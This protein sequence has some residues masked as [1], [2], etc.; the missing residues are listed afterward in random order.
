MMCKTLNTLPN[1]TVLF[2]QTRTAN[3]IPDTVH[4]PYQGVLYSQNAIHFYGT[5]VS[6][7]HLCWHVWLFL[8]RLSRNLH[9]ST[10][11]CT[12]ILNCTKFYSTWAKHDSEYVFQ[13]AISHKMQY[14][15]HKLLWTSP[16]PCCANQTRNSENKGTF[17]NTPPVRYGVYCSDFLRTLNWSLALRGRSATMSFTK[18]SQE[19][20]KL[21]GKKLKIHFD[22]L[23]VYTCYRARWS[24]T[25]FVK[26]SCSDFHKNLPTDYFVEPGYR[27][28]QRDLYVTHC[29]T[30]NKTYKNV[31]TASTLD[32]KHLPWL[33][34]FSWAA[35]S[36]IPQT[37]TCN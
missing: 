11:L 7:N 28:K 27:Q 32:Y 22:S 31:K 14:S 4:R 24:S 3:G 9:Q 15:H 21:L 12:E 25:V 18:I 10:Q 1:V 35:F 5:L 16:V 2:P 8:F 33:G 19:K 34:V 13:E 36:Y 6:V 17:S 26:N 30:L 37:V 23:A 29:L 20:W